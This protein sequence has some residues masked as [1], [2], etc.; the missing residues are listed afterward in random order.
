MNDPRSVLELALNSRE[1]R[2]VASRL[3]AN[4]FVLKVV[5][6]EEYFLKEVPIIQYKVTWRLLHVCFFVVTCMPLSLLLQY[7]ASCQAKKV[8]PQFSLKQYDDLRP[9]DKE[10]FI[11]PVHAGP[12]Q[13]APTP[14]G[15]S[16]HRSL[17]T[18]LH[19][20][21]IPTGTR[22]RATSNKDPSDF[23]SIWDLQD[24]YQIKVLSA[25]NTN[26]PENFKVNFPSFS[27]PV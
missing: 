2:P 17:Q 10:E 18:V 5:G 8:Q 11:R 23:V 16:A 15:K 26:T 14:Y 21:P 9:K 3:D 6:K 7:I 24:T 13:E 22:T 25:K 27:L 19:L 1:F 12:Q 4:S 20:S